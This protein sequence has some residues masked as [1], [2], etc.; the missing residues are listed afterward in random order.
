MAAPAIMQKNEVLE[1][2]KKYWE[3]SKG[4]DKSALETL[5]ADQFKP[6]FVVGEFTPR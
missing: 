3:A 6:P 1:L 2:E 5:T 4:P